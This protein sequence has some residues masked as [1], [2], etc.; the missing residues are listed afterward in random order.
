MFLWV[1]M[2]I[3]PVWLSGLLADA[4]DASE[5]IK[6]LRSLIGIGWIRI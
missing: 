5:N 6:N 2:M 4:E 3:T 1:A